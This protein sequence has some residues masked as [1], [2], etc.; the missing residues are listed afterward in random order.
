MVRLT[1]SIVIL[2]IG[3]AVLML[4]IGLQQTLLPVRAQLE[5]FSTIFIGVIGASYFAGFACGC[6]V[7]PMAV[8][9]VGHIRA[10]AGF[11]AI[12]AASAAAYP[13]NVDPIFWC[14]LRFLGG[15]ALAVLYMIIE[16]WLN[17]ASSNANRGSVLSIYIIV[18]NLVTMGGQLMLNL[19][20]PLKG[21]LFSLVAILIALSLVPLSLTRVH[22]PKPIATAR[23]QPFKL[24]QLSPT[25][26]LGCFAVG[27]VESAFWSLGPNYALDRGLSLVEVTLLMAV[28]VAGG[29]ISQWPLGMASDRTDRRR[30]I[31]LCCAGSVLTALI[32]AFVRFSSFAPI[33]V[34]SFVHGAL[35]FPLYALCVAHANDYAP[36]DKLVETSGGLLLIYSTGAVL[37]P[38]LAGATMERLGAGALFVVIAI[39]LGLLALYAGYRATRRQVAAVIDRVKFW[40]VP[41]STPTVYELEVEDQEDA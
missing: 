21:A 24:L 10:F 35:M 41:K 38:I 33:V 26:V 4:G 37:G 13:L 40:P 22:E 9:L 27:L 23:L 36:D 34:V 2:M 6:M 1:S 17:E 25:G 12:G 18:A 5:S 19:Y 29:T 16:S 11:A 28:F 14:A 8:K 32:L 3:A 39:L 20:D 15:A 31:A 30:V 7:G